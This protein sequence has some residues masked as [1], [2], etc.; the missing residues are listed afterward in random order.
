MPELMTLPET[1]S[2]RASFRIALPLVLAMAAISL[3]GCD[4]LNPFDK[5][6][7]YKP[8][9]KADVPAETLYNKGIAAVDDHDY[10]KA[11]KAFKD[12]NKIYPYSQWSKKSLLLETF[13]HYS[14]REFEEAASSG[15][16]YLELYPA[17]PDAAYAAHLIASS[18]YDAVLD[19]TKDQE[20]AEKA[21]VAFT[22]VAQRWPKSDYAADA[23][24]K[25]VIL[26]DQLAAHEMTI[27]RF[28]LNKH[29]YTAAI[30][31]FRVVVSHYQTTNQIEEALSR[32][33]EAYL[34]LG[35]V[36]EAETAAAVLGHNF[37]DS[38][39]YK[40]TYALLQSKGSAPKE[41]E[42]S[43]ISKAFKAV[44]IF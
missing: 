17:D 16:R 19:V 14:L 27:G 6:E 43:W 25:I 36:N 39:W 5:G 41:N 23:K 40:D 35:I 33:T 11:I 7:V 18:Y 38:Q 22:E 42:D 1:L 21:L 20:R 8:E 32:L 4:S 3:A 29:N 15:K 13:S 28:Y 37:P 2:S 10:E 34:A 12:I 9:V 26:R 30:N 24:S 31:R 44:K